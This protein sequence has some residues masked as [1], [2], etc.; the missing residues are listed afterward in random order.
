MLLPLSAFLFVTLLIV[1]TAMAWSTRKATAFERHLSDVTGGDL[2]SVERAARYDAIL[3]AMKRV[4]NLAPQSAS[5][6]GKLEK[7]LVTA[8]YRNREAIVVFF[9]IRVSFALLVFSLL[10]SPILVRPNL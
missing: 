9:G 1:G 10:A 6:L 7:R 8:G 3:A 4:G 2:S 5:E